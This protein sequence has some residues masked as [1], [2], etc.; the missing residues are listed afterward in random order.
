MKQSNVVLKSSNVLDNVKEKLNESI[1]GVELVKVFDDESLKE[2]NA[3]RKEIKDTLGL[4]ER[5]RI[6]FNKE[7]TKEIKK[8]YAPVEAV[9]ADFDKEING[10][11]EQ[12]NADKRFQIEEHFNK[13]NSPVELDR[14]WD[15]RYYN[16][17]YNLAEAQLDVEEK[18]NKVKS[19]I[20]IIG[21]IDNSPRLKELY[22]QTLDVTKAKMM[23]DLE[24]E[25]TQDPQ[26]PQSKGENY[27][28]TFK[29]DN[30]TLERITNFLTALGVDY[31]AE[32][33]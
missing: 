27:K 28:L 2:A 26:E 18:V 32:V 4:A 17:T 12:L 31:N 14:L 8:L 3:K 29:T 20:D 24:V 10:Y 15:N 7:F 1:K 23:F 30:E 25:K 11:E 33:E 6:D 21:M 9:I 16:K 5:F 22:L 19:D 13:L